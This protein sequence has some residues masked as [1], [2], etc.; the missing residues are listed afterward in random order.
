MKEGY[1]IY[2]SPIEKTYETHEEKGK[3]F[4]IDAAIVK[5]Q[6]IC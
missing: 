3:L 4:E 2:F 6:L 5:C 1:K